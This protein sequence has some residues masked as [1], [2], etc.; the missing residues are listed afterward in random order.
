VITHYT[1]VRYLPKPLSGEQI[2][3]GVIAW[4]DEQHVAARF[5]YDWRRVES[6]VAEED[7][8][9]DVGFLRDFAR[10]VG[11]LDSGCLQR[12]I[13]SW[14][15]S[16]QFSEPKASLKAPDDVLQE[17]APIFLWQHSTGASITQEKGD[18]EC[19]T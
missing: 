13:K 19:P 17:I 14:T 3:I 4:D 11:R 1:V 16:I 10:R 6:F 12:M 9:E 5:L 15:K 8:E 7:V 2:N 18:P